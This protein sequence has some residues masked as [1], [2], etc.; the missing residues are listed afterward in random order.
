AKSLRC[1]VKDRVPAFTANSGI[2]RLGF[3]YS[4]AIV[5]QYSDKMPQLI[6]NLGRFGDRLGNLTAQQTA[7]SMTETVKRLFYGVFGHPQLLRDLGLRR[8][9]RFTDKKLFK[10]VEK[11]CATRHSIFFRKS[12]KHLIEQC[13]SPFALINSIGGQSV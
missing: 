3:S 12:A 7:I 13:Q 1:G 11:R 2:H 8:P 6:F 5:L 9:V 4:S 10:P